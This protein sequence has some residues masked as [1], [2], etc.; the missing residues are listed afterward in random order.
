[1]AA[2]HSE[3]GVA[4]SGVVFFLIPICLSLTVLGVRHLL[5]VEGSP[6]DRR[7]CPP[8][9]SEAANPRRQ[10]NASRCRNVLLLISPPSAPAM[11]ISSSGGGL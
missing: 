3:G 11:I 5:F 2:V 6:Q 10:T 9:V 8:G 7:C 1:M 4:A